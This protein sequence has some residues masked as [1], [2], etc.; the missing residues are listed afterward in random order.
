ME[1]LA[2]IKY[3]TTVELT[4]N[5]FT[6]TGYTF[7][8]WNTKKDGSGKSYSNGASVKNLTTADGKTVTFYAQWKQNRYTVSFRGNGATSGSMSSVGSK[9][10]STKWILPANKFQR[11]NHVF[12]GWT[13]KAD[14]S[15]T[16]Y[17]NKATVSK[18][19]SADGKKV[20][21]YAKW[22]PETFMITYKNIEGA[23]NAENPVSYRYSDTVSVKL[24]TP[25]KPGYIFDGWYKEKS[26]RNKVSSI[27][28][29]SS[30][31][32]T[33]WAKWSADPGWH[34]VGEGIKYMK[35]NGKWAKDE[36]IWDGTKL[37]YVG[38]D[39]LKVCKKGLRW[40]A[41]ERY[42]IQ[43]DTS[44]CTSATQLVD[45]ENGVKYWFKFGSDGKAYR[46]NTEA[47]ILGKLYVFD[48]F[49]RGRLKE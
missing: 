24:K 23:D 5:S 29:G 26:F 31:D 11:K 7:T 22:T 35:S 41:G 17:P 49:G 40:I 21:L 13:L 36:V 1:K 4:K 46:N 25:V 19:S 38:T 2:K 15:G 12:A 16:V 28:K 37:F 10:Y 43:E 6:R 27:S 48:Q 39:S 14:G 32:V 45:P 20:V 34:T 8:G 3:K 47:K 9:A 18:L 44:L 33:L 30:G 42:Y